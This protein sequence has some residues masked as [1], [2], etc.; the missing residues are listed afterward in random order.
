MFYR[1]SRRLNSNKTKLKRILVQTKF[2]TETGFIT[3]NKII[4]MLDTRL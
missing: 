3:I 4:L 2:L 1:K